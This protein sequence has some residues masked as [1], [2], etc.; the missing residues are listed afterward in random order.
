M[1][2][3]WARIGRAALDRPR[4]L[5]A[6]LVLITTV[7]AAGA[8]RLEF[9]T[10]QAS[11]VAEDHP[12]SRV[13]VR[14]QDAFGGEPM[15]VLFTGPVEELVEPDT[16]ARV[17][18]L[19]AELRATG[20]FPAVLG[21]ATALGFARDQLSVAPELVLAA[22]ARE[23]AAAP[24]E[25]ARAEVAARYDER[26][27]AE[28]AR[29]AEVEVQDLSDPAFTRFLLTE[30]DGSL[31]P[32]LGDN[33]PDPDHALLVVRL[34]GNASIAEQGEMADEI[35]TIVARHPVPGFDVL[36]TGP[37]VLLQEINEYL[38]TGM[39]TLG[40]LAVVAMTAL[41]WLVFRARWRLLSLAVVVVGLVWAF[42]ALGYL[43]VPLSMVTI[44]GLPILLGLGVDFAVQTHNRY[45]EERQRGASIDGAVDAVVTHMAPPLTVAMGAAVAG[46]LALQLTTVP[47]I[48]DFGVLLAVGMVV[49]VVEATVVVTGL[50]VWRDRRHPLPAVTGGPGRLDRVTV[51]AT[52]LAPRWAIPL[53][54]L[55]LVVGAAGLAV[56]GRTPIQTDPEAWVGDD[57]ASV[58][59]LVALRAATGFSSELGILIEGG[60]VTTTEVLQWVDAYARRQLAAHPDALVRPSSLASIASAVTGAPPVAADVEALRAVAPDDIVRS[61]GSADGR[62]ANLVFPIAPLSL[63]ERAALLEEMAADLDPPPGIEATP[64]GLAVLGIE[65]VRGLEANRQLLTLVALGLVALWLVLVYRR[66]AAV[67]LPLLPVVTAVGASA[68]AI[69]LL[70]LELTPLTTVSG[71]LA[72]AIT[73]EF[74]V[75]MLA[76][77]LEERASG[78]DPSTAVARAAARIGRAFLASGL[79]LLGGFVVLAVSPMPLLVDFGVVVA[80]D[81]ALALVSVLIV[82]PP[83]LRAAAGWLPADVPAAITAPDR[84]PA[85]ALADPSADPALVSP[86]PEEALR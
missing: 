12:T 23:Q 11:L 52:R 70:G 35:R 56:E 41:L 60:D 9:E 30:P 17:E 33:F 18:A 59:E 42:G 68:L 7:L 57:S 15:I 43:G 16:L 66:P 69:D 72:I 20:R 74:S 24:D 14:Y 45:E 86:A 81:V 37:P 50:L 13:S 48:D 21:P 32:A 6:A 51:R 58:G 25:A 75:L 80:I 5:A 2:Q 71:P 83:L 31:R 62:S 67:V 34:P 54:A 55:G 46:F 40:A 27:V 28:A 39:A 19:E 8:L 79:T 22:S 73:T 3:I 77:F 49:L 26:L 53:A 38:R 76:R 65:L 78:A 63:D 82:L 10:S 36:A 64:S 84:E 47:M 1:A 29:L 61:F 85:P 4:T 44:S